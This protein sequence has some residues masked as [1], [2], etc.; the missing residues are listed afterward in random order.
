MKFFI[1]SIV[2]IHYSLIYIYR[3][4]SLISSL[5]FRYVRGVCTYS[6]HTLCTNTTTTNLCSFCKGKQHDHIFLWPICNKT[7][8]CNTFNPFKLIVCSVTITLT[9]NWVALCPCTLWICATFCAVIQVQWQFHMLSADT[10]H[11]FCYHHCKHLTNLWVNILILSQK[12]CYSEM[13][14]VA[15]V[16][17]L[18]RHA[19]TWMYEWM[20]EWMAC[21]SMYIIDIETKKRRD[22]SCNKFG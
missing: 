21:F 16:T 5:Y 17:H 7:Q 9:L 3:Q 6:S 15:S 19:S 20:N 11:L 22:H 8:R 1:S 2:Y 13:Q 10:I 18:C 12:M 4:Y 14:S